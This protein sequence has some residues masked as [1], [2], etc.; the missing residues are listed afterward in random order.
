MGYVQLCWNERTWLDTCTAL[1]SHLQF[2]WRGWKWHLSVWSF[3]SAS[4]SHSVFRAKGSWD[5][6]TSTKNASSA[7]RAE[8]CNILKKCNIFKSRWTFSPKTCLTSTQCLGTTTTFVRNSIRKFSSERNSKEI[9]PFLSSS[10]AAGQTVSSTKQFV[11]NSRISFLVINMKSFCCRNMNSPLT[12]YGAS[13]LCREIAFWYF[14]EGCKWI[15]IM[16]AFE[17]DWNNNR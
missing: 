1:K 16:K 3:D 9:F 15:V 10:G 13:L 8:K 2:L 6:W 14:T 5:T 11:L 4:N 12:N 7:T 17:T